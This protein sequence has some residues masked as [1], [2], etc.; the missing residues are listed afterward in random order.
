MDSIRGSVLVA[1]L[2]GDDFGE[3]SAGGVRGLGWAVR[4]SVDSWQAYVAA[5]VGAGLV[6]CLGI[7]SGCLCKPKVLLWALGTSI[8]VKLSVDFRHFIRDCSR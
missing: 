8:S 5:E 1:I 4:R 6:P 2:R 7:S 3:R